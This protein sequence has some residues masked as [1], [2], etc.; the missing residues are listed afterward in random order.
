MGK[1]C[2]AALSMTKKK[3]PGRIYIHPYKPTVS[4]SSSQSY[5]IW[6]HK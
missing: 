2:L 6:A 5:I 4:F 1:S 3:R